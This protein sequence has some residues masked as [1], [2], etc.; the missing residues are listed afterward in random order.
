[1]IDD[2]NKLN[3]NK[4]RKDLICAFFTW[5]IMCILSFFLSPNTDDLW[6]IID[7]I[8]MFVVLMG[9]TVYKYKNILFKQKK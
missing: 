4:C 3:K 9:V 2:R 6:R 7:C 8:I 5:I 1:M